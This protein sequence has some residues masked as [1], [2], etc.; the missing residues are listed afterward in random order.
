M[1]TK[2][3]TVDIVVVAVLAVAF[4][5]LFWGMAGLWE[6]A[7]N[8]FTFFPP[9]ATVI[10]GAWLLPAVLAALIIRKPGAAVLV[11]FL[12]ALV[13]AF[14]GNKWGMTVLLQGFLEGLGAELVFAAFLYRS[15][16][17]P[18][19]LLAA[20]GAG[21]AATVFDI[22]VWYPKM[23]FGSYQL[24]YVAIGTLS[25]LIVAGLGGYYLTRAL[26]ATGVLDR[27][28]SGKDRELV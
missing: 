21:L 7:G 14:L 18:V 8:A 26:A 3:R 5:V 28:P 15:Y 22:V 2:W 1:G 6:I 9:G 12:A 10:Y 4:G 24:P 17:P 19:A 11:E 27:F 20:V 23:A 16:R 13:S 25:S